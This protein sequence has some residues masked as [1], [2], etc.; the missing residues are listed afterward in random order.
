MPHPEA[1]LSGRHLL[2]R[3]VPTE[4]LV[5]R[6]I[7]LFIITV[8]NINAQCVSH[9]NGPDGMNLVFGS[10]RDESMSGG[11]T[12]ILINPSGFYTPVLLK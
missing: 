2:S 1:K 7:S 4:R 11:F 6:C 5:F 3:G 12:G 9:L 10:C 8:K